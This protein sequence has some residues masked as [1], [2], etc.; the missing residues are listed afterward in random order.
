[1]KKKQNP[2]SKIFVKLLGNEKH[3]N[4]SIPV[5][6][7]LVSLIVGAIIIAVL[8][9][10]PFSAYLNLLQGSG[11]APKAKYAGGKSMLTDFFS[12]LDFW[13][14]MIFASLS[15]AV[16][17][18]AGLFNIGVS[19]QMLTAGFVATVLVGYSNL[20]A[21]IA[22]P[23]VVIIAIVA[24]MLVGGL[25]G[26]LKYKFNI[27]EVVS[28]IMLNY[29]AINFLGYAVRSFLH[30]FSKQSFRMLLVHRVLLVFVVLP[31]AI[32]VFLASVL[33]VRHLFRFPCHII[34]HIRLYIKAIGNLYLRQRRTIQSY[35]FGQGGDL[36]RNALANLQDTPPK[37]PASAHR[38]GTHSPCR[39]PDTFRI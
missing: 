2:F 1:M 35:R 11:L 19:G 31:A 20:G 21:P 39:R 25:I 30:F 26:F 17:M 3:Q 9:K 12:F 22:K 6:A 38:C 33:C 18:K 5:F 15:V 28:S 24:G 29:I 16:A 8:G 36:F 37:V 34:N 13:T 14:P 7:I 4:L 23:L 32:S 27:N 10:N